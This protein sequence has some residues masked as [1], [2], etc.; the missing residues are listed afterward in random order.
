LLFPL[1]S[2]LVEQGRLNEVTYFPCDG[3]RISEGS[4]PE[5]TTTTP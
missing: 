4:D 1:I 5:G 2:L 3:T